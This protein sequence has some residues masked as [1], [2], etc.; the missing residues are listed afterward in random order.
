MKKQKGTNKKPEKKT[1]KSE[2]KEEELEK[3]ILR[4][5]EEIEQKKG[6]EETELEEV[7]EF[8][9]EPEI[10]RTS[11]SLGRVNISPGITRL[12]GDLIEN[13]TFNENSEDKDSFKYS[14]GGENKDEP[15]YHNYGGEIAADFIPRTE[16]ENLGK[17]N[18]FERR[19]TRFTES[20]ETK[21][22]E[23][24]NF[25]RYNPANKIDTEQLGKEREQRR[26]VKYKPLN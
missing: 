19:E 4:A 22:S 10:Q 6:A 23:E 26:E 16:I 3:E 7:Q 5:E 13:T 1:K 20:A 18:M 2:V 14:F 8:L 24:R 25:E 11:P 9:E 12:E 15:K 17:T 21:L